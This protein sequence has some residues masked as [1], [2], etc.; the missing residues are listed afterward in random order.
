MASATVWTGDVPERCDC[1][2]KKITRS[3]VDGMVKMGP[4]AIM[5]LPCHETEGVGIGPG[6]GQ[7]YQGDPDGKFVKVRG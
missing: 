6:M 4:W 7:M 3:F 5:C 2:G 1:C